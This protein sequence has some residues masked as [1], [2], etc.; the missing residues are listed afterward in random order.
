M[1]SVL[2]CFQGYKTYLMLAGFVAASLFLG[3]DPMTGNLAIDGSLDPEKVQVA[4][5]G[6]ALAAFKAAFNRNSQ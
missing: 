4:F 2:K 3:Q 6:A 5:F 1:A